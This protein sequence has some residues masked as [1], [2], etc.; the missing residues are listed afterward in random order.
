[1]TDP[2]TEAE[3][4]HLGDQITDWTWTWSEAHR[5]AGIPGP[6]WFKAL[7]AFIT[8]HADLTEKQAGHLAMRISNWA[9]LWNLAA[10]KGYAD[11]AFGGEW[12]HSL[13]RLLM[14]TDAEVDAWHSQDWERRQHT[15][16]LFQDEAGG[17]ITQQDDFIRRFASND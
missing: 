9:R 11:D 12:R 6:T 5:R 16:H 15:V 1:M 17:F 8:E 4:E 10:D 7:T 2:F 3:A 14:L 13:M